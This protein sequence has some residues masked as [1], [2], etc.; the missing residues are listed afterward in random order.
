MD[1]TRGF[2]AFQRENIPSNVAI[3]GTI[4]GKFVLFRLFTGLLAGILPAWAL[5][6][7][8]PVEVLKNLSTIKLLGGNGFRKALIMAQFSLSLVIIIFTWT[9]KKQLSYM[10]TTD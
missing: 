1:D 2:G 10:Q 4:A 7:F 5:S 9:F 3:D 6:S 8:R